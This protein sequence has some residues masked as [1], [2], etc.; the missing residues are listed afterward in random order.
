[1]ITASGVGLKEFSAALASV[2][3]V[4]HA[5]ALRPDNLLR[6]ADLLQQHLS[7]ERTLTQRPEEEWIETLAQAFRYQN[8]HLYISLMAPPTRAHHLHRLAWQLAGPV[9]ANRLQDLQAFAT[10]LLASLRT[11]SV[12]E[13]AAMLADIQET[14]LRGQLVDYWRTQLQAWPPALAWE[15][16]QRL[17]A[18]VLADLQVGPAQAIQEMHELQALVLDRSRMRLWLMGDRRHLQQARPHVE[19]LVRSF[20][21]RQVEA[22]R[23]DG[24]PVVWSRLRS[25]H[26]D[27]LHG[28]PVYVGYVHEGSLTGN[29]VVTAKGPTYRDLDESSVLEVLAGKFL[30]GTGAH[31]WYKKTWE[32]GLAYGNGLD[33]RPRQGIILYYAD[34]CPSVRAT[35]A[36]VRT[37]AEEVTRPMPPS[38][39]DYALAQTFAFSR[40]G[41]SPSARAEAMAI[42]L[43]EGL[44]PERMQHFSQRLLR[45][46]K[47]PQLLEQLHE[48]LPRV[49]AT[50][51]LGQDD[52]HAQASA[53]S[54]FFIIAPERQLAELES[55]IPGEHLPRVWPRDFWLE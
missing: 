14:G 19:A 43:R 44:T 12:T 2:Q 36:F 52:P 32:A 18:E 15:G 54:I 13:M 41:L 51:A 37:M 46:R 26:P 38:A 49:V 24:T 5:N 27:L 29:V 16:L 11:V 25:R 40:T 53:Q 45:I 23:V 1:M 50:V 6:I 48:A 20:L 30:A 31:T 10:Q 28:Y 7:I 9:P 17:S 21:R 8:N 35:L 47:A 33:V 55:D 42:D 4:T 3:S 34:R 22:P 39:V